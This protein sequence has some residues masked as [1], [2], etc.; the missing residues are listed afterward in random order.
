MKQRCLLSVL[1]LLVTPLLQAQ[2]TPYQLKPILEKELQSPAVVE[3]QLQEYLMKQVPKLPPI[4]TPEKWTSEGEQIRKRVLDNVVFHG[5]P[6]GWVNSPPRFEDLG[7]IPSG[8]GYRL[9]KLRY[10]VVPGF[11]STALLYEPENLQGKVPAVLNVMG[12]H[13]AIGKAVEFQ[14]KMCINE[15]LRGM[16]ALNLEWLGMGELFDK[17]NTHWYGG[18]L[19][20][21]GA[22]MEG[23]FY[24]AMRRGL[25]YL[26]QHPNVDQKRIAVTGLSGGGWQ[27][28]ILSSLDERVDVSIPVAGYT[29][30]EG[31]MALAPETEAGD[32][33]QNATDLLVGQDYSTLT[34]IRAPRPTLEINN[35]EDN[36]C[37]R[38]A[39]VKPYIYEAVR[40][41]FRLYGKEE[42]L[43]FHENTNISAHNYELDDRHQAYGFLAKHFG[44]S[45]GNEE[46]DVGEDVKNY[47]ELVVGVPPDNLTILGL[48][49]KLAGG[50][51]RPTIPS[52]SAG[53]AAWAETQRSKLQEVLRYHPVTVQQVWAVANTKHNGV[54]SVSY[55]FLLS[56][57][58]SATGVWLKDIPTPEGAPLTIVIN[59]KGKKGGAAE[60]WDRMP[61]IADRMDRN[62]Q[63]L[64]LDLVFTGDAAPEG[65][66]FLFP[67]MLAAAGNR[68]LGLEAAQLIALSH[69]GQDQWHAP[70]VRIESTGIRSQVE[71]LVATALAPHAFSEVA[72]QGGM[73]SLQYLLDK[74][75]DYTEYAD[76]FC[77]DLYKD[78]DLDRIIVMA[79]PTKVLEHNFVEE[80]AKP[81]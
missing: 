68:S 19:D 8:K 38:A 49:R 18:H 75:I 50:I 61:E 24:L 43:Q 25:D 67:E 62:E 47:S 72:V 3:F 1:V 54:E 35:A 32:L 36:C 55:R 21:V 6:S 13:G 40:P 60:V 81:E 39:L 27:T 42:A 12:H 80:A 2:S 78:F 53:K 70:S 29:S 58:L 79:E 26:W 23:L 48:A 66:L 4:S 37:F 9:R 56:N 64:V 10:E 69:W 71:A 28:I 41:F 44:L 16:M 59:D 33:E 22:N 65:P 17:Q 31:R 51:T 74:P 52:D 77:L 30:L 20:L 76:L 73:H 15:A 45:A 63:V 5:W 34:A 46:I 7:T 57:G 11:Y 14:Q